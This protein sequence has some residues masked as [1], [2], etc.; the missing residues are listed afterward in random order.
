MAT[1]TEV[2]PS[3]MNDAKMF[4]ALQEGILA[5]IDHSNAW[6]ATA[7]EEYGFV[8]GPGQWRKEDLDK[9]MEEQRP[10]V[11]F[12]ETLKFIRAVCGLEVNNRQT[13]TFLPSDLTSAGEVKANE[14]LSAGSDWMDSG[15]YALRKKSRSFRDLIICGM[16]WGESSM[17]FDEDPK[18]KYNLE[19]INPLEMGWDHEAREQNLSDA[20]RKWRAR[21]MRVSQARALIPGVTDDEKK[22]TADDLD[23]SWAADVYAPKSPARSQEQKEKREENAVGDSFNRMVTVVQVQWWEYEVYHKIPNPEVLTNPQAEKLKDVSDTEFKRIKKEAKAQGINL[24]SAQ[25]RRKVFKQAFLGGKILGKVN[26]APRPDGFT[27]HCMTGEP[28]DNEGTWFGLMRVAKDPQQWQ[29]KFFAQLMH[30]INTTAK[31]GILF[32]TDAVNDVAKFKASYAKPQAATEVAAGAISKNK[33]TAKPGSAITGGVMQLWQMAREALPSTLGINLEL[34]GLADRDQAGILEAQRKQAAMTILA[35]LFDSLSMWEQERG[36]AKLYFLQNYVPDGVFIRIQGEDGYEAIKFIRDQALGKY[37]V[38]VD[39]AP[40]S[41]NM[42][43]KAWASLQMLLPAIKDMLT[44]KVV[45]T[46]LD[47]VPNLPSKLVGMLKKIASEPDPGAEQRQKMEIDA[48]QAATAKDKSTSI[49]NIAKA[50]SEH[51]KAEAQKIETAVAAYLNLTQ[52]QIPNDDQPVLGPAGL[53]ETQ[54]LPALPEQIPAEPQPMAPT[55]PAGLAL[56]GGL[57]GAL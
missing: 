36:R 33:I 32:E 45:V 51:V 50:M 3:Q 38:I 2:E 25:M 41:T 27:F 29:N 13:T 22:Y 23:A 34:M 53:P 46:L 20:K 21:R 24:P 7:K 9:L 26:N 39:D 4:E 49:L 37:D 5:D 40:T 1:A 30:M 42:K 16:G 28:D 17:D 12:N 54:A 43:D 35:T 55:A 14:M 15:C 47:Y 10:P 6:R 44:P 48:Q 11:T 18:G 52:P 56:P 57:Q 31:G 8:A 19:R